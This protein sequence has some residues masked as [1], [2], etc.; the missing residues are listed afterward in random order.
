M[1]GKVRV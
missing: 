1:A